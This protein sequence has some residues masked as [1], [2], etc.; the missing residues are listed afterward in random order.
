[1]ATVEQVLDR[2]TFFDAAILKH[3]FTDYMRDYELIVSGRDGP[4][5]T[6]VHSYQFVGCVEAATE[7]RVAPN[8]FTRSLPDDFVYSGPDY[9]DKG[10]PDGFVWGVRW[11]C[12]YPGLK[13]VRNGTR[14]SVWSKKL[15]R[16]MHEVTIE[17]EAFHLRLVFADIRHRFLGHD[18]PA[19]LPRK[20]FP[21]PP[22]P[23][24]VTS[25][26]GVS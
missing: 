1:M 11:S 6:D 12:A 8:V 5:H 9:P 17:T 24:S 4:P 20:D 2:E 22:D 23:G 3:G 18:A 13:Y 14:A 19:V 7:T 21:I 10:D 26:G 16:P 25:D 15:G